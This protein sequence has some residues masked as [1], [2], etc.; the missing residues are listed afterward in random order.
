MARL[1][2]A[3][4][5]SA[6]LLE[7]EL[8]RVRWQGFALSVG[9]ADPSYTC[10]AVALPRGSGGDGDGDAVQALSV[11]L[12]TGEFRRRPQEIRSALAQAAADCG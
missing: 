8:S 2:G 4:I 11:S 7:A 9:E 5:T 3:T 1:T 6:E 10:L 12:P